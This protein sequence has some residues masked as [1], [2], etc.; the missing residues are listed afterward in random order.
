MRA[1]GDSITALGYRTLAWQEKS[2]AGER[3]ED[4]GTA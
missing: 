3:D 4:A 1:A 2:C